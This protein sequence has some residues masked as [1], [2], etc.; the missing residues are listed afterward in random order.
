MLYNS[1]SFTVHDDVIKWKHFPRN[2]P[3][4]RG[5]HRSPVNSSHTGLWRGVLVFS[6]ICA[7]INRW[8]NNREVGDLRRHRAHYD[9]TVMQQPQSVLLTPI[10]S[11]CEQNGE[12]LNLAPHTQHENSKWLSLASNFDSQKMLFAIHYDWVDRKT[13]TVTHTVMSGCNSMWK[14]SL[15]DK[16]RLNLYQ[17]CKGSLRYKKSPLVTT[18]FDLACY[19]FS[20]W[21]NIASGMG[22]NISNKIHQ[23]IPPQ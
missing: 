23:K 12:L 4:G 3:F 13:Y 20:W 8:V 22:V 6:L 11:E 17:H 14:M 10:H 1:I 5:I 19:T 18:R 15:W 2:W 21:K 16:T 7:W 9:F